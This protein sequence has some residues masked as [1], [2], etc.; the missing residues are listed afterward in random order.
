[1]LRVQEVLKQTTLSRTTLWRLIRAQKFPSPVKI[2]ARRIAW[3]QADVDAF[4][5]GK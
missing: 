4:I 1:M 3:R 5:A 2:S